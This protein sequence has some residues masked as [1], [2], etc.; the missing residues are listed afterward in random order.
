MQRIES[1]TN[2]KQLVVFRVLK[3]NFLLSQVS[4]TYVKLGKRKKGKKKSISPA[5][6]QPARNIADSLTARSSFTAQMN[7]AQLALIC[8]HFLAKKIRGK[9]NTKRKKNI[10]EYARVHKCT[11]KSAR[12]RGRWRF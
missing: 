6:N 5:T 1:K 4:S 9:K 3:N 8:M 2:G 10:P 11:E 12:K 7:E